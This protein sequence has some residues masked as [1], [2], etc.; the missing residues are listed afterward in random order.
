[1]F[2]PVSLDLC[3]TSL[4]CR[5]ISGRVD[6]VRARS[7]IQTVLVRALRSTVHRV[8]AAFH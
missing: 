8:A 3:I 7:G 4:P 5:A 1:M 2:P 6:A